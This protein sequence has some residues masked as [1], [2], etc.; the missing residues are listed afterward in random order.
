[1]LGLPLVHLQ[2]YTEN[3]LKNVSKI[4]LNFILLFLHLFIGVYIIWA[5]SPAL[6]L[7]PEKTCSIL[8]FS[9]FVV[10]KTKEI[11]KK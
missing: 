5:T 2:L 11:I 1:M 9:N 8:F 6:P 10:D 3:I 7:L 4:F